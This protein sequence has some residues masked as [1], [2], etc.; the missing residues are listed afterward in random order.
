MKILLKF[1]PSP[2]K[3]QHLPYTNLIRKFSRQEQHWILAAS[4]HLI[5]LFKSKSI[6]YLLIQKNKNYQ[7]YCEKMNKTKSDFNIIECNVFLKW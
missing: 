4:Q 7:K 6:K 5:I 2:C 1:C 3:I